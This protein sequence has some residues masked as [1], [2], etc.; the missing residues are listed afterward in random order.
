MSKEIYLSCDVEADGRIPGRNSMLS[1]GISAI[2]INKEVISSFTRNL[3]TL[4]GAIEDPDTME[5]W[6]E[7]PVAW[8]ETTR[9]PQDPEKAMRECFTWIM[10]LR[11]DTGLKPVLMAFPGGYDFM[12]FHW[13]MNYFASHNPC[14]WSVLCIK[15]YAAAHLKIDFSNST[16]RNFPKR[17]FQAG[18]PHTHVAIDDATEQGAL[19]INLM[20]EVRN[21]PVIEKITFKVNDIT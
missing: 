12:F 19:A 16:K 15:S 9:N 5:F 11:N 6:R 17:W 14:G 1:F 4:P 2:T 10:K 3:K 8:D 20:R 18:L 7:N 21:L 13:Y